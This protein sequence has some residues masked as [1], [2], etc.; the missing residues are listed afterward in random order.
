[1]VCYS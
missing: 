1:M